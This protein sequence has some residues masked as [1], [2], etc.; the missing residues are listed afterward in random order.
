MKSRFVGPK[1]PVS[2]SQAKR[3]NTQQTT[4]IPTTRSYPEQSESQPK[5]RIEIDVAKDIQDGVALAAGIVAGVDLLS[6]LVGSS[7]DD[8]SGGGGG[9][10][11]GGASGDWD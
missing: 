3:F 8:V 9:F 4:V 2:K 1:K 7:S 11:G 5:R 6:S 10:D